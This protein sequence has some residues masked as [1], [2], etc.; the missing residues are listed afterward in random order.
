MIGRLE[1][2]DTLYIQELLE[3]SNAGASA[4]HFT[5]DPRFW[6]ELGERLD[7]SPG[8]RLLGWVHTHLIDG[9]APGALSTR[10]VATAHEHFRSPWSVAALICASSTRPETRWFGWRDGGME[11]MDAEAVRIASGP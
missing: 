8:L 11:E 5:F 9:G 7:E 10:D 1:D 4:G 2:P 6:L 3:A